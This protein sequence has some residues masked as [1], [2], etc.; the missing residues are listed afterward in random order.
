MFAQPKNVYTILVSL[1]F[2]LDAN[3]FSSRC[4]VLI[5]LYCSSLNK[6]CLRIDL[7]QETPNWK[8]TIGAKSFSC[9]RDCMLVLLKW[10]DFFF[11]PKKL[12]NVLYKHQFCCLSPERENEIYRFLIYCDSWNE[13]LF[14]SSVF[15]CFLFLRKG[16]CRKITLFSNSKFSMVYLT[17]P[18]M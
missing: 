8:Y 2:C 4:I 12:S 1:Y 15:H 13:L 10:S 14:F 17:S 11:L 5:L 6:S 18:W 16:R 9:N 3:K 7:I